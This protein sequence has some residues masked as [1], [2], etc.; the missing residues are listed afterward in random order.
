MTFR[1]FI[2]MIKKAL[3][4]LLSL[5]S[6]HD[7]S[8]APTISSLTELAYNEDN[9]LSNHFFAYPAGKCAS[10]IDSDEKIFDG[11]WGH[12][13]VA[14]EGEAY[15]DV[16]GHLEGVDGSAGPP[17]EV[18][19]FMDCLAV[20][21]EKGTL[22]S[23]VARP[24]PHRYWKEG[25]VMDEKEPV[26]VPNMNRFL[27]S[28]SCGQVEYG[29]ISYHDFPIKI[30]WVNSNT[31]EKIPNQELGIGERE[32]SFITTFI[33]HK[34]QFYDTQPNE[35]PLDNEM[36]YELTVP[37]HG[38][39]GI[40]NHK[41][42]HVPRDGVEAEVTRTLRSEW[43]RHLKIKRT[44]SALAFDKGRLPDD[45]FA[46]LGSYYYNN[47][48]PPHKVLEEWGSHKGVFVNYWETDVNFI[49]IPWHLK[50]RWQG[51]LLELVE[52]W[53][54]TE[55]EITDMYGMREYTKGARLLTHVDRESTHAASLIVNIAQENVLKPWTVEVHDHADR[56]HEVVMEPGDIVYYESAKALHGRNTPLQSGN[57]INL[58]TH[59]RPLNDPEW[60]LR[61]TP[62]DTPKPLIDVG[63]CHLE[64]HIDQYSQGAVVCDNSAIGPHLSPTMFEARNGH[65][66]LQWWKSVGPDEEVGVGEE[67]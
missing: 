29:F 35:D 12:E 62:K 44:F 30:Y 22:Q 60:F 6:Q 14:L 38:V 39:V 48:N 20:C 42:P 10:L 40:K 47:R 25:V 54:G 61:D 32:T 21:L 24:L 66:L 55:L 33:G 51:R 28:D 1:C 52:A 37:N 34:F 49:Q 65:D 18:D 67:L 50:R 59:Y 43:K 8:A 41:Q 64:K 53:S 3:L 56:L 4:S 9:R 63:E 27:T 13:F 58:F 16:F 5:A 23:V 31:G 45:M 57:Y 36:L 26:E 7:A 17:T 11:Q 46:S 19:T 2:T 15:G